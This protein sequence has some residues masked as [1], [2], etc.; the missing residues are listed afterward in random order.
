MIFQA[1]NV[2]E[3]ASLFNLKEKNNYM[4][5]CSI[6]TNDLDCPLYYANH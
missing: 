3:T 5:D 1:G 4:K 2:H 6:R